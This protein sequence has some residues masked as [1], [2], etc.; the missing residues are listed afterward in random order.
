MK[1]LRKGDKGAE[2]AELQK[3][4][5]IKADG[6]FGSITEAAVKSFQLKTGLVA[7][8]IAGAVTWVA[9]GKKKPVTSR[10]KLFAKYGDPFEDPRT[11]EVQW[12]MTWFCQKDF[13]ELPF[14]KIYMNRLAIPDLKK[15]FTALKEKD[16]L[17]EIKSYGGCWNVRYIRGYEA[18]KIP[19]IHSFALAWDFNTDQ[20]PLGFTKAQA[21]A[22]GL[23]PFT[24]E[25][26]QVWRD[27]GFTCGIDF[28]RGDGMHYQRTDY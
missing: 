24:E 6:D 13:P 23:T 19:S 18:Q 2:V 27:C 12:M 3:L 16:L 20:N 9:L 1:T 4:L 11:F 10:D 5:G 28:K 14:H 7:D 15:V 22:K 25:F 17:K 8:G 26:D 21:R